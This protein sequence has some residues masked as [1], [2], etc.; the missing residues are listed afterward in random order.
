MEKYSI[1]VINKDGDL[2]LSISIHEV[3]ILEV[4]KDAG[5][6]LNKEQIA[7]TCKSFVDQARRAMVKFHSDQVTELQNNREFKNKILMKKLIEG[8]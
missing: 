1:G 5:E 3:I 2:Y 7:K 6:N 4:K 8:V